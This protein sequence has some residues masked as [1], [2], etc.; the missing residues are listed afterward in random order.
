VSLR[1]GNNAPALHVAAFWQRRSSIMPRL[2]NY[3]ELERARAFV[4]DATGSR[5]LVVR[6]DN[7]WLIKFDDE[8]Y[9][10]FTSER[11]AMR[12]AIDAARRL[13]SQGTDTHVLLLD[14]SGDV[15]PAWSSRLHA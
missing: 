14:G 2:Q 1:Q 6:Q 10:P 12:I 13:A 8:E 4:A 5:Y 9:G 15:R 3:H 11:E 7:L